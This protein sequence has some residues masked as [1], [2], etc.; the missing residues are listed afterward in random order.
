MT[1]PAHPDLLAEQ[2]RQARRTAWLL[3]IVVACIFL[4]YIIAT[5]LR[6]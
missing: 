4:G 3:G 6:N 2:R 5:G 1:A